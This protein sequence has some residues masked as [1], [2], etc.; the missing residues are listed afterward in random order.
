MN[1]VLEK[2]RIEK[3]FTG[4]AYNQLLDFKT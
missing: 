2:D 1:T 3:I 4:C